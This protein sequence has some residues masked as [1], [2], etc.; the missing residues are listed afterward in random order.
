MSEQSS[1]ISHQNSERPARPLLRYFG[2]KWMLADWIISN[3]PKHRVY[4][5]GW[6]GAGSVLLNKPRCYAEVYNDKDGE[7]VN[8]FRVVR[9]RG[10]ELVRLLEATPFAREEYALAFEPTAD[11]LESAR[12]LVIRSY[13]GFGSN[14]ICRNL[15]SGFRSNSNR[16]GTTPAHD[17]ANFPKALPAIIERLRGVV[18]ENRDAAEVMLRHDSPECL[19]YCDPPYVHETRSGHVRDHGYTHEMTDADHRAMAVVLKELRG[20]VIVSGYP[21]ALYDEELFPDWVR[22]E[23]QALADGALKRT[24]VLW[25][26]N[27]KRE[28]TLPGFH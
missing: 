1:V 26:R 15:R 7:V 3:F 28:H 16:S 10:P 25:M 11:L 21:C 14:S 20:A 4:V 13:M 5:E 23:R 22:L 12:R 19:H 6:G 8:L 17:W 24:E 18:I 2:G 9:D 27:V